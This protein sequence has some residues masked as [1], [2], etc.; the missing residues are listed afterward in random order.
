MRN[1]QHAH[2]PNELGSG[3]GAGSLKC[4]WLRLPRGLFANSV[5]QHKE[6]NRGTNARNR[7]DQQNIVALVRARRLNMQESSP[8]GNDQSACECSRNVQCSDASQTFA[9]LGYEM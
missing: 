5:N 9:Y 2:E 1:R 7:S 6:N 4:E 8:D 3:N